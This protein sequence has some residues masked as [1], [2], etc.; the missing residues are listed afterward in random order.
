MKPSITHIQYEPYQRE[1]DSLSHP[2]EVPHR[3]SRPI[4]VPHRLRQFGSHLLITAE[5]IKYPSH[6]LHAI[7]CTRH[8]RAIPSCLQRIPVSYPLAITP[9]PYPHKPRERVSFFS[10]RAER[11]PRG[12]RKGAEPPCKQQSRRR[13][14][15]SRQRSLQWRWSLVTARARR[16]ARQRAETRQKT[17][18]GCS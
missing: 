10:A 16:T 9:P 3:L 8:Y 5:P 15:S 2:I 6:S 14:A 1:F 4:E 11:P 18:T 7:H 12:R 17:R 13:R